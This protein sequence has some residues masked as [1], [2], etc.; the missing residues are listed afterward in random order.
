MLV[1]ND[2]LFEILYLSEAEKDNF[3]E[4]QDIIHLLFEETIDTL[5]PPLEPLYESSSFYN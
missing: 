3:I 4:L 5:L 1:W 2:T